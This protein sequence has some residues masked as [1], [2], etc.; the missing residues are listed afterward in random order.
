MLKDYFHLKQYGSILLHFPSSSSRS[1]S[2]N[3]RSHH[4]VHK[5]V[6]IN[7]R[8]CQV[9]RC[10]V[11]C[12][13]RHNSEHHTNEVSRV[14]WCSSR[15]TVACLVFSAIKSETFKIAN[16]SCDRMVALKGT[17]RKQKQKQKRSYARCFALLHFADFVVCLV[18]MNN[19]SGHTRRHSSTHH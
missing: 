12:V 10:V 1:S 19:Y 15:R 2:L 8:Q 14:K 18:S 6:D 5:M 4:L 7:W 3:K 17:I 11:P 9:C 16:Y 13:I